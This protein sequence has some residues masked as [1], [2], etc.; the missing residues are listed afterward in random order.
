MRMINR[1]VYFLIAFVVAIVIISGCTKNLTKV[2]TLYTNDF[3]DKNRKGADI[4]G[5]LPNGTLATLPADAKFHQY[6]GSNMIGKL[7]NSALLL[8]FKDLPEHDV[9]RVEFDLYVHETWKNDVF[10]M[11]FD[12]Q[13]RL[14]TGFSTDST[15]KQSYPNWVGNGSLLYPAGNNAQEIYLPSP[16]GKNVARGSNHYKMIQSMAHSQT[17]FKLEISDSGGALNDTCSRSWSVDNLK[18]MVL[19]NQ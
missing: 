11:R 13:Y 15:V 3:N 4:I 1:G 18:I 8:I 17:G 7:N 14:I 6:L 10:V 5:W 12:D 9:V 16:C 19:N 2:T